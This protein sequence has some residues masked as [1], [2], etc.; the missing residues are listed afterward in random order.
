MLLFALACQD[1]PPPPLPFT[2]QAVDAAKLARGFPS[3]K[4]KDRAG[5]AEDLLAVFYAHHLP[6]T[7]GA[8]CEVVAVVEQE[9]GFAPDPAVPGIGGLVDRWIEEKQATMG[10][11]PAWA[12]QEGLRAVLDQK[13]P[14]RT[15]TW[16][17]ELRAAKTERDVD[18]A[19]RA[20]VDHHRQKLPPP[21]R[22]AE[23]AAALVG[24]DLDDLN[25]ITTAGC[26]QVKVDW[27]EDHAR[28]DHLE[29]DGVRDDLYTR[30]G[31]LHYGTVRLFADTRYEEPLHR[32][33][34]F[35]A[36]AF[37][38]RNAAFQEQVASLAGRK[39]A[40][41]GDLLIYQDGKPTDRP[42]ETL[43]AVVEVATTYQLE[44]A[45]GR[46]R[47]DLAKGQSAELEATETWTRLKGLY[48]AVTKKKPAY[49]RVPDL[50]LD[51]IKFDRDLTTA[52]FAQNVQKRYESCLSRIRNK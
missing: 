35:N 49:A 46:I 13:A 5:W 1:D 30:A 16:N 48:E 29:P 43:L 50:H 4:V 24:L 37:A 10:K 51:S 8:A 25:P 9:S 21:L 6:A 34:D 31:C 27:A 7:N 52:W 44:L 20:F 45:E 18:L 38:S 19:F 15:Q 28:A 39:L 32:F 26:M 22:A 14:G 36:G 12:F 2:E 41:D 33:A 23:S 11:L 40:L 3:K 47:R 17:E 42:S